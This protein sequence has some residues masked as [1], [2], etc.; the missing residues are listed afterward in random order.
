VE[1]VEAVVGVVDEDEE[2]KGHGEDE[3]EDDTMFID[4]A[5]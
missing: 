5:L 3:D 2:D 1:A 4:T